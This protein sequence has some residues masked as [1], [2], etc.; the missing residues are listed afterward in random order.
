MRALIVRPAGLLALVLMSIFGCEGPEGPPTDGTEALSDPAVIPEVIYT[1]PPANS[2]GPYPDLTGWY[3]DGSGC[4]NVTQLQVRFNKYMDP[5]SVRTSI[6]LASPSDRLFVDS[7]RVVLAGNDIVMV[8]PVE[9]VY[10]GSPFLFLVGESYRL[11]V[12]S[13]A[14]DMNGNNLR[15]PFTMT[16]VPEPE[17]RVKSIDPRDG[18]VEVTRGTSLTIALNSRV[19]SGFFSHVRIDP[20]ID[21]RW[22]VYYDSSTVRFRPSPSENGWL[23]GTMFTV[24]VDT[25]AADIFGNR[26]RERFVSRFTTQAFRVI[27]STPAP[28]SVGF[29]PYNDVALIFNDAVDT[30]TVK[31]ALRIDPPGQVT[32]SYTSYYPE[33]V[34]VRA[35]PQFEPSTHYTI[36]VDTTLRSMRGMALETSYILPFTTAPFHV[37][38]TSPGNNAGDVPVNTMISV[39]MNAPVAWESIPWAIATDPH[40]TLVYQ[41][42]NNQ[43][44]FSVMPVAPLSGGTLYRVTLNTT[45]RTPSGVTLPSEYVFSFTTRVFR[46]EDTEPGDGDT[47]VSI[48]RAVE[49]RFTS[50][51][52]TA[53]FMRA[54][55]I[56]PPV[57]EHTLRSSYDWV[58]FRPSELA[59]ETEYAWRIDTTLVS[60]F[61]ERMAGPYSARF[62]T[63]PFVI[64]SSNPLDGESAFSVN[65][66]L[67]FSC[68]A[69]IASTTLPGCVTLTDSAGNAVAGG[70]L[71][72]PASGMDFIFDP[73]FPLQPSTMYKVTVSTSLTSKGGVPLKEPYTIT[74]HTA[75]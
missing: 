63:G 74:F 31:S 4:G 18:Q 30:S 21:G 39:Q 70:Y 1:Y 13:A 25:A 54:F 11:T 37:V 75:P 35:T 16:F 61:G 27:S 33:L 12:D 23:P 64:V 65:H 8:R 57:G 15:A 3:C 32:F 66:K 73:Y 22:G 2:I 44:S 14:R 46:I 68:S 59:P 67:L 51:V 72:Y 34:R 42:N 47:G 7:T 24:S 49:V 71:F 40:I 20:P 48:S 17:F 53:E 55:T 38:Y 52:D 6:H 62:T 36:T 69:N 19:D 50:P 60:I 45:L 9:R 56:E 41:N 43:R 5:S 10:S 58:Y 28:G 26:L 29:E